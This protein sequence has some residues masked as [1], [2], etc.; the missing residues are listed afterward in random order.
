M[1]AKD[2]MVEGANVVTVRPDDSI[3]TAIR[4]MLKKGISGLPV[5]ECGPLETPKLVG[6]V[7]EGDFLRRRETKT[8]RRRPSWLQLLLGPGKLADEYV[9]ASGRKISDV[10]TA[11]A[12]TIKEETTIED[13]VGLMEDAKIKRLPVVRGDTLVG[14]VTRANL[15]RAL[16]RESHRQSD[17]PSTDKAIEERVMQEIDAQPWNP[18]RMVQ[19]TVKDGVVKLTG[20]IMEERERQAILVAI[21]NVPGVRAIEDH[22]A[23]VEP[24]SGMVLPS[25]QDQQAKAS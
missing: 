21:E 22:I 4:L 20:G 14:I 15:L 23:F 12:V 5:V 9:R 17:V 19:A 2:I 1:Q 10:M 18:G 11:P 25:P 13:I 3:Y 7:T 8:L 24:L 16:V 6:I